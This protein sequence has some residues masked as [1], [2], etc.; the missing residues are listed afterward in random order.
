MGI[1]NHPKTNKP[2]WEDFDFTKKNSNDKWKNFNDKSSR[3][4][5]TFNDDIDQNTIDKEFRQKC[6]HPLSQS[7]PVNPFSQSLRSYIQQNTYS[8]SVEIIKWIHKEYEA[9]LKPYHPINYNKAQE[10]KLNDEIQEKDDLWWKLH[11]NVAPEHVIAVSKYLTEEWICHKYIS[12]WEIE[13]GKIFTIYTGSYKIARKVAEKISHDIKKYLCK[14]EDHHEMELA[15][16]VV[17]RF[18]YE[19]LVHDTVKSAPYGTC[20]F[21]VDQTLKNLWIKKME[22]ISYRR[23]KSM[24]GTYFHE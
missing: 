7:L 21:S 11:I 9:V 1:W 14:P 8:A 4:R 20:W 23:L 5:E 16:G 24:F 19:S 18:R 10:L 3:I 12:W 22:L 2:S 15:P 6:L 13:D 17:G